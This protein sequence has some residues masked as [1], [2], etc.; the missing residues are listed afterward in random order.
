MKTLVELTMNDIVPKEVVFER[1]ANYY[2]TDQMGIV[3]HSNYIRWFEE[4]RLYYMETIGIA[5]EAMEEAGIFIPVLSVSCDYKVSIRFAETV[6]IHV[7]LV[8]FNGIRMKCRYSIVNKE[9]GVLC[10]TGT[11]EHCFLTKQS[12]PLSLKK[13]YPEFYEIFKAA[14]E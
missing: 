7:A 14:V 2:E 8:E 11:S 10:S 5:Y 9:T 6:C 1:K 4:A 3:H 13:S 12:K